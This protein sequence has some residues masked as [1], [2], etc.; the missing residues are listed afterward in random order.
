[1]RNRI[2]VKGI[3]VKG[4]E[5]KVIE[6]CTAIAEARDER[7]SDLFARVKMAFESKNAEMDTTREGPAIKGIEEHALTRDDPASFLRSMLN[8]FWELT[9]NSRE[10]IWYQQ[11]FL[12]SVMRSGGLWPRLL[13]KLQDMVSDPAV[14]AQVEELTKGWW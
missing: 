13:T 2:E 10:K 3:E 7:Y 8:L 14:T 5:V 6:C 12:P 11:P 9:H 1:M 4:K